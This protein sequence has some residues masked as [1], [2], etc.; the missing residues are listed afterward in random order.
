MKAL[1]AVWGHI[2]KH[3]KLYSVL[4]AVL[5]VLILFSIWLFNTNMG[6]IA[7]SSWNKTFDTTSVHSVTVY[8]STGNVLA[9]YLGT[10]NV[11]DRGRYWIIMNVN[12]GE[13]IN[14]YGDCAIILDLPKE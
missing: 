1:K 11:E 5:V 10:Y 14:V 3:R 7:R 9:E 2:T 4:S 12:T 13:R 6:W 8:G